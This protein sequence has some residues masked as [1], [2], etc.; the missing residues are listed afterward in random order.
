MRSRARTVAA[1]VVA[2]LAAGCVEVGGPGR[3]AERAER[4]AAG[5]ERAERGAEGAEREAAGAPGRERQAARPGRRVIEPLP[6]ESPSLLYMD[7]AELRAVDLA[8]GRT[9]ALGKVAA[10]GAMA[11]PDGRW[12]AAVVPLEATGDARRD[13]V[14]RPELR[15]LE[16][17][18]GRQS[19]VGPGF[20]PLW[21]PDGRVLVYLRPLEPR[22]CSP[23]SCSGDVE[24]VRLDIDSGRATV[25]LE[26]GRWGLLSWLGERVLVA[27]AK[28]LDGALA[29]SPDG[30]ARRIELA[31]SEVWAGSPDGEWL[32][33]VRA[34]RPEVLEV[35]A[36]ALLSRA[37][38]LPTE[39]GILAEGSWAPDSS[40]VA[41][42]VL[43]GKGA[44]SRLMLFA[45]HEPI[46]RAFHGLRGASGPVLWSRDGSL[47]VAVQDAGLRREVATCRVAERSCAPLFSY[48]RDVALVGIAGG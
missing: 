41:S 39:G 8:S 33:A 19:R 34:G 22:V 47:L 24:V 10:D 31:P 2:L 18:S 4:E 44:G 42:V 15:L 9:A 28:R 12:I 1:L 40:L 38:V 30:T 7:G 45:P 11:S 21:A 35:R 25:L 48:A 3:E 13:F 17:A 43:G 29:V 5:A 36:G 6:Q 16:V 27:D 23:E 46:L 32:I 20:S 14:S 26:A 37:T